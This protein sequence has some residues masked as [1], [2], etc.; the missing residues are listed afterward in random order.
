MSAIAGLLSLRVGP[1]SEEWVSEYQESILVRNAKGIGTG[2]TLFGLM[3]K[4]KSENAETTE[5]KWF[6]RDPVTRTVYAAS[7]NA[8]TDVTNAAADDVTFD[9][10]SGNDVSMFL[11]PG[12]LL[13]SDS[14]KE[15]IRILTSPGSNAYTV[16]RGVN[17]STNPEAALASG[18]IPA[19][20][21]NSV[22]TVV[23]LG[24]DEGAN[25]IN[26]VY[27]TADVLKNYVQTFNSTVEL[28]NAFKGGRLRTDIAGP[29]KERRIQALE[30]VAR[31]IELGYLLGQKARRTG[32][33]GYQ[34]FTGGIKHAVDNL[35]NGGVNVLNGLGTNGV[36]LE[37][38][39]AWLQNILSVG[40]DAKLF[41]CGPS[42]YAAA[43][44]YAVQASNGYRITGQENVLGMNVT[45]MQTPF[46]EADLTMHPLLKE[47][48][49]FNDWIFVVD[50]GLIVQKV[51]EPLFLEPNIQ[52]PGQDAYKEQ[53]RAKYGL[54]L[55]FAEAFGYAYDLSRI[56]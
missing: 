36:G 22:W 34:Y 37:S 20:A 46:G 53:F 12:T 54:K 6:E 56:N 23:T 1:S 52:T 39:N 8:Q 9:D 24:K 35:N 29:L 3:A 41:F 45:V 18:T 32:T 55:K 10:G 42:A 16:E 31:D 44:N 48:P 49:A 50:L 13:M 2:A 30:R 47:L 51:M 33:N 5:F 11:Q 19:I 17:L 14:T 38:V 7:A 26:A 4:L 43:S 40:S 27:E 25:P 21:D 15:V 28:S